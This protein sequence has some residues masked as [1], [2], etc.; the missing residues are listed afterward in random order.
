M[1][2][3]P[4][5]TIQ[6]YNHGLVVTTLEA[7]LSTLRKH[8]SVYVEVADQTNLEDVPTLAEVLFG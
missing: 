6:L 7:I 4:E 2:L 8:G 5:N 3:T 1:K